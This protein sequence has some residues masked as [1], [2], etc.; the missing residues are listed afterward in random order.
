MDKAIT[1]IADPAAE[2]L[3][4]YNWPGNIRELR[5]VMERAVALTHFEQITVTD[6]PQKIRD[7]QGSQFIISGQDPLELVPLDDVNRRYILHVL[8]ATGG[9]RTQT[10][11]ILGLDRK[12]LYRKLKQYGVDEGL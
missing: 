4:S 11:R 9:N 2:R 8:E 3:L 5:N 10:A 12:T 6:L 7:Y 1:G